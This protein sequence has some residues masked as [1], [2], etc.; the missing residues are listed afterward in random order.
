MTRDEAAQ[1]IETVL[2]TC[3][4]DPDARRAR[5]A[6]QLLARLPELMGANDVA[7]E[8]GTTSSN[9]GRWVSL[10]APLY[11]LRAGRFWDADAI[12][13]LARSRSAETAAAR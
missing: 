1:A 4:T 3:G 7:R 6:L 8:L 12:R 13:A 11:T 2:D 5:E 10:P 9:L